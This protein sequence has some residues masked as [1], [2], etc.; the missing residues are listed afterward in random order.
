MATVA[1][2][3]ELETSNA[4][5]WLYSIPENE[6]KSCSCISMGIIENLINLVL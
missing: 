3:V 5:G 4:K 1:Q 2:L 6:N